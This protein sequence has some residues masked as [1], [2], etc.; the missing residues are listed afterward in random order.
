MAAET[1]MIRCFLKSAIVGEA[2]IRNAVVPC[3]D[4]T[5]DPVV[6]QS[7]SICVAGKGCG[8]W[9]PST[10]SLMRVADAVGGYWQADLHPL[11]AIAVMVRH[12]GAQLAGLAPYRNE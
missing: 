9:S 10:A 11:L 3:L 6:G 5:R 2:V 1:S 12:D 7:Q 4:S 8:N